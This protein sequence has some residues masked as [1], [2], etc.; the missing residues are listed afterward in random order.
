VVKDE[1]DQMVAKELSLLTAKAELI[2]LNCSETQLTRAKQ[3]AAEY[4][5]K[6][7]VEPDQVIPISAKLESELASLGEDDQKAYLADLG[8]QESGLERLIQAAYHTLG[9]QSFLT[10][11]EKEVRAWTIHQGDTAPEAAGEIHTDFIKKFI[12]ANVA[13]Y[14]DFVAVGGWKGVRDNGKLRQEGRDY[15]MQPDDVV[16]FMIGS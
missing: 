6:F 15:V 4:A 9:L 7:E 3:L 13:S 14:S 2:A 1:H 16:E 10:A 11:G 12:R 8:L 5:P